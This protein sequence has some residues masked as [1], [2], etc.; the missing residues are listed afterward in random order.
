MTFLAEMAIAQGKAVTLIQGAATASQ[1]YP[2]HLLPAEVELVVTTDDGSAGKKGLVTDA[3]TQYTEWADQVFACG[4][5]PMYRAIAAAAPDLPRRKSVQVLL[6]MSMA[7][8]VGACY[9]CAVE[10]HQGYKLCCK[11]GPRF[12]LKDIV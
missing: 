9:S 10:T 6:E 7:C 5:E 4:P 2:S 11:D 8:G 3:L 1:L 12:E